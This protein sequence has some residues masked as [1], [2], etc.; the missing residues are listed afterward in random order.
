MVKRMVVTGG[1]GCGDI[2]TRMTRMGGANWYPPAGGQLQAD[3]AQLMMQPGRMEQ[4]DDVYDD[5]DE[6]DSDGDREK[7]RW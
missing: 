3:I 7:D 5:E 6:D 2:V 4:E 1:R